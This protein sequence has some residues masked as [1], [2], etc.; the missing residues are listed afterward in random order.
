[1]RFIYL[2]HI[3]YRHLADDF[4]A[5]FP[6]SVVTTPYF[7]V[8]EPGFTHAD[9]RA[10]LDESMHA[11]R[12][13]FDAVGLTEH[14]QSSYDMDPNPDLGAAALAYQIGAE[15]L[16]TGIYVVGRSLGKSREPLRVAEEL[17]WLDNLSAGRLMT[18]F[19]VGLP[20]DANINAGIPPIETRARYDENLSFVL[21]AWTD[22]EPFAWNGKY[23][24][25][26]VGEHL[27]APIPDATPAGQHHRHRKPQHRPIRPAARLRIQPHCAG[28]TPVKCPTHL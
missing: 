16:N 3:P 15:D 24:A 6:E 23:A 27:A 12:A 7:E 17:A 4:A 9:I 13:G 14:G 25:I 18:G 22:R 21:K 11:A 28:R 1:M 19:P 5:R 20:Y 10:G 26:H 8:A 2:Q